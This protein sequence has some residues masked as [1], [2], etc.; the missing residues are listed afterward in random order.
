MLACFY[1]NVTQLVIVYRLISE[2]MSWCGICWKP[3]LLICGEDR[4]VLPLFIISLPLSNGSLSH[5]YNMIQTTVIFVK[6]HVHLS[7]H[8]MVGLNLIRFR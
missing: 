6:V 2:T 3:L 7:I 4:I 5:E 1:C 8:R